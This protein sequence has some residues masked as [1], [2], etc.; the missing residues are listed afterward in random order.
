MYGFINVKDAIVVDI[1]AYIGETALLF[2]S[3][4]ASRVY[5]LEPV[6]KHY[7]Y[8]LRNIHRNNVVGYI[9]PLDY[10]A[11][12]R[13]TALGTSYEGTGTGLHANNRADASIIIR[14]RHLGNILR[15]IYEREGRI[16]LVKMDCEGC[17]YS[18][19]SLS[20]EDVKLAKQYII[21]IHGSENPIIDKM[22]KCGYE[23]KLIRKI[24]NL[25]AIYHFT[26]NI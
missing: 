7:H 16:N 14:V 10:G 26:Q 2:L 20:C 22:M 24:A 12:F 5:A 21:E 6:K 25:I 1:G 13:E 23:S 8:L 9:I 19:L 15:E 18:L 3:R 4:G 17:E 11:W